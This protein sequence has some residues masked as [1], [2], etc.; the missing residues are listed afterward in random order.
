MTD[1]KGINI[2]KEVA[3]SLGREPS[4][5]EWR[6]LRRCCCPACAENGLKGLKADGLTGFCNRATH[7]L[8]ILL[9]E[10]RW[11]DKHLEA[12]TYQRNYRRRLDN[13]TYLPLIEQLLSMKKTT[14]A[15]QSACRAKVK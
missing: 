14:E 6:K 11:L 13:S 7:N 5:D 8:W 9:D 15:L 2:E 4:K 3:A 10:A 1:K 12:G